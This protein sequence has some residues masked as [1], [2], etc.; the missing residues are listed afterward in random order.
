MWCGA[1]RR[2]IAPSLIAL[3]CCGSTLARMSQSF[4]PLFGG[5]SEFIRLSRKPLLAPGQEGERGAIPGRLQSSRRV[6]AAREAG[7]Q[8]NRAQP[9]N[10][11]P[12]HDGTHGR[13]V[14]DETGRPSACPCL[15][16]NCSDAWRLGG[17]QRSAGGNTNLH[18]YQQ[19]NLLHG[20]GWNRSFR[21]RNA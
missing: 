17:I 15:R 10:R 8:S 19:A 11:S 20:M 18:A 7:F 13:N 14:L 3:S 12:R 2:S 9:S 1:W 6:D 16:T 5:F 4:G 21:K